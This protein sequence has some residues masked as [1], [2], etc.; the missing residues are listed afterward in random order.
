MVYPRLWIQLWTTGA[1]KA[2]QVIVAGAAGLLLVGLIQEFGLLRA[3]LGVAMGAVILVV[4]V[5]H[6][7]TIANAPV[8]PEPTDVSEYGLKYV[9]EVCGLELRVEVAAKD[10]APTHCMEPM[11]LVRTGGKPPLRP[12]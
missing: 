12:L 10:R 8:D 9:C 5:R 1:V 4:G 6:L 11:T 2:L 7:Q 3:V